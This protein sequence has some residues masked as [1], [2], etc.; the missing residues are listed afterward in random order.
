MVAPVFHSNRYAGNEDIS[1]VLLS[2]APTCDY[3]AYRYSW[4]SS[5]CHSLSLG[6]WFIPIA[7][8]ELDVRPILCAGASSK[9][10]F[11]KYKDNQRS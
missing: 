3:N 9:M 8:L 10:L 11:C 4:L 5:Y 1:S 7:F 2:L 6:S